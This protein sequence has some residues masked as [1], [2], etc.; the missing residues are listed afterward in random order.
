MPYTEEEEAKTWLLIPYFL[1][2]SKTFTV[3]STFTDVYRR[4]F[5]WTAGLLH[6]QPDA[7]PHP[8]YTPQKLCRAL[9]N[10]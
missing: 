1:M 9:R 6:T 8:A 3:P 10:L 2:H 4:G 7:K 5:E